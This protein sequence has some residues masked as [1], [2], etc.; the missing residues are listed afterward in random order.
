MSTFESTVLGDHLQCFP[1]LLLMRI[2]KLCQAGLAPDLNGPVWMPGASNGD[3]SSKLAYLIR[4][5]KY[6]QEDPGCVDAGFEL[7]KQHS[8]C[9]PAVLGIS[10]ATCDSCGGHD[11]VTDRVFSE[12]GQLFCEQCWC[13]WER[14]GWWMPSIRVSTSPPQLSTSGAPIFHGEDAFFLSSFLCAQDDRSVMETLRLELEAEERAM[15]E[16]HGAR[17]LGLQF[18]SGLPESDQSLRA[19]LVRRMAGTLGIKASAVRL[20][21]YRSQYDYKPLHYDR[22]RDADGVPQLTVGAS[23]GAVREL[24]LMHVKSGVTMSFPQHNGDVFAFTPELNEVFMHGVPHIL[25]NSP[26]SL[27]PAESARMS[28]IVW[29]ARIR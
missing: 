24:T 18:E 26:S 4:T 12:R 23:F 20:N 2:S 25:P 5:E 19:Q 29:G 7:L 13:A 16:W 21:L 28:L 22:G 10:S 11:V 15:S 1:S 3:A 14:C 17:H 6:Q 27:E 8:K 9:N